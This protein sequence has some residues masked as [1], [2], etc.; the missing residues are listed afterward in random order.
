[1]KQRSDLT[2]KENVERGRHGWIR[3]TP[4]YSVKLVYELIE[5][6]PQATRILDPFSGTGTTGLAA[7]EKGINSGLIDINPFLVWLTEIKTNH[8][9]KSDV[10]KAI[11]A[12]ENVIQSAK[13]LNVDEDNLWFP[14]ISNVNRW[15][16]QKI[17]VVL[18][19]IYH[20]IRKD[21]PNRSKARDLLIVT[22]CRLVMQW[23]NAAYNHQSVS[24]D[25][26]ANENVDIS[27]IY[28]SFRRDIQEITDAAIENVS[29]KVTVYQADSR[30]LAITLNGHEKFDCVITSPP[31][32]NRMSYV[33]ELRPYMY[34]LGYL[35]TAR[36]AGELDWQKI[37][38]TWGIATSRLKDWLPATCYM[39]DELSD[40]VTGIAEESEKLSN[41]VHKYTE[42]MYQHF[43]QLPR[44]LKSGS[45]V[46]YIV[47][48]SKFYDTM[49][50]VQDLYADMMEKA[51]FEEIDIEIV[52]KR[53]SKKELYEYLVSAVWI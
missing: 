18:A 53:N 45:R 21:Y 33:R 28:N 47:G 13:G 16:R 4:A 3:L 48:N 15:W 11:D 35:V 25:D 5:Q 34:W 23:S 2:F 20:V 49:V 37:G 29:G 27:R 46:N 50:N 14:P 1:M 17:L 30:E 52:R 38:G 41:Y 24:F 44:L 7:A 39:P 51:G 43:Q 36:D 6:N 26:E 42:D 22:F 31:Y 10:E 12:V 19:K 40:T 8:Y 9:A 32:A